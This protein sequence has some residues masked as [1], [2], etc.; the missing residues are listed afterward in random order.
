MASLRT[1]AAIAAALLA[2]CH[3]FVAPTFS[4]TSSAVSNCA[5]SSIRQITVDL[6]AT[7]SN[8]QAIQE[9]KDFLETGLSEPHRAVDCRAV[10]VAPSSGERTPLLA[11][12]GSLGSGDDVVL[13]PGDPLPPSLDGG[14]TSSYP[15]YVAVRPSELEDFIT[16]LPED[17]AAR[18][19]DLVFFSGG[20]QCGC[21]ESILKVRGLCRDSMTQVLASGFTMP[22]YP[23]VPMDLSVSTGLDS[24]GEEKWAGQAAV[25]GK[26]GGAFADRLE[27]AGIRCALCFYRDWRRHMWERAA[28]D[29]VLNVVGAVRDQP[30]IVQQ[31]ALYYGD[32]VS[33]ML[34]EIGG[35]LR[36]NLAVTLL[37][38]FESRIFG[39]GEISG[40]DD[41]S[42]LDPEMFPYLFPHPMEDSNMIVEYL[43]FAQSKGHLAGIVLPRMRDGKERV[44]KMIQ[45]NLR[46]D[47]VL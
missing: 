26:W 43:N 47:G 20:K 24:V 41:P 6:R 15:I 12:I 7:W 19:E 2:D 27:R 46:A 23:R 11:A 22:G 18:K 42:E 44:S 32:E 39:F 13:R 16:T 45:G 10:I 21:I 9:Y 29:A 35:K 40:K 30:T 3:A 1:A 5:A 31:V 38:G 36:G 14:E 4:R 17:W 37:Y 34:W 28:Y 8:G 33:D 25:C